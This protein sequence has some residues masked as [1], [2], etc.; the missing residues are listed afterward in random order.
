MNF[1]IAGKTTKR[2]WCRSYPGQCGFAFCS[3]TVERKKKKQMAQC[4]AV[5]F[6]NSSYVFIGSSSILLADISSGT[7]LPVPFFFPPISLS[8]HLHTTPFALVLIPFVCIIISLFLVLSIIYS[9]P[10][11]YQ[12]RSDSSQTISLLYYAENVEGKENIEGM[13]NEWYKDWSFK[14]WTGSASHSERQESD[15]Q[16]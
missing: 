8:A 2:L 7:H 9:D 1:A 5:L 13:A 12:Y 4:L 6:I 3:A 15:P 14:L 10:V 16:V 11:T